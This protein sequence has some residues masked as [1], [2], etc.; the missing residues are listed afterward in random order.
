MMMEGKPHGCQN[1]F[2]E[3]INPIEAKWVSGIYCWSHKTTL[4]PISCFSLNTPFYSWPRN[5]KIRNTQLSKQSINYLII[6]TCNI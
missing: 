2:W 3:M 4:F 6:S 1:Q 5:I